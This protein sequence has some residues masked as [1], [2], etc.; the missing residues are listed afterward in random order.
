MRPC[1]LEVPFDSYHV[2]PKD[3]MSRLWYVTNQRLARRW[4][5][6]HEAQE[7]VGFFP[8]HEEHRMKTLAGSGAVVGVRLSLKVSLVDKHRNKDLQ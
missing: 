7:E 2:T 8:R 6:C 1:C 4:K 5:D 3:M